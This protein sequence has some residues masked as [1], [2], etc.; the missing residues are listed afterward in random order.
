EYPQAWFASLKTKGGKVI[1]PATKLTP[2]ER[3]DLEK[4]LK[5]LFGTPPHP[6]VD[7]I[8]QEIRDALQLDENILADGAMLY[9]RHCLH[10]HGLSGDGR[11]HTAPWI[12][13]HPRDFRQGIF[14]FTSS[15]QSQGSQRKPRRED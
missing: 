5:K 6:K 10:C 14:K 12:N 4:A 7:G 15:S 2:A 9:R 3:Q 8:S 13:P 11:G 1:D